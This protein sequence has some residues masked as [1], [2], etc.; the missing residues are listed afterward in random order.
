[1][2]N[3]GLLVN[4]YAGIGGS[5]ALKGSD[6]ADIR[7]QALA[8]GAE[9][10]A[11]GRVRR[12]LAVLVEAAAE[13]RIYC[14]GGA[15]GADVC[16]DLGLAH[17]VCGWP[18]DNPSSAADTGKAARGLAAL[19]VDILL[20]A[21][22]DG[23]ARDVLD[24]VGDAIAVLGIPCG[25]KMHS[26]VFAVSPEAAGELM[27]RLVNAGL[28][29]VR[30]REVRDI[31][32]AAFREGRVKTRFYGELL[33]PEAGGYL[34][35]TKVSGVESS[36]LVAQEIA[37]DVVEGMDPDCLYV[38]GPGSTTLAILQELKLPGTLLGVDVI[39]DGE[40]LLQDATAAGIE[41]LLQA[42]NGPAQIV[43]TAIG[44]QGHIFGR[45]NQQISPAVI[46]QV[47]VD[48]VLVVAGKG[49]ITG[50]QG[51]PLLVDSND[52]EL[53]RLLSG[54]RT[55]CTGYHDAILYPVAALTRVAAA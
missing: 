39:R 28:V 47:G 13:L 46:R 15:M 34:Q 54:Y 31:D 23:T 36:E 40:L 22:G 44:G 17:T 9:Q 12:A 5:V 52:P 26:G 4:P 10:R 16:A 48:N 49:K 35:H 11:P 6:G 18:Q 21:G 38:I 51:R 37:A 1:M 2:L 41:A 8:L 3:I 53:D 19:P 43:V 20:F 45:G 7:D 55:V 33:T 50:L 24:A 30:L 25:V 32:E 27:L 14:W 42:H 29:D